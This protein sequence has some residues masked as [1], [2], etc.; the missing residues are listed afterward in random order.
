MKTIAIQDA[1]ILIDLVKTGLFGHCLALD[2]QFVTTDIVLAELYEDQIALIQPHIDSER[3]TVI[4]LTGNVLIE[5]QQA[6]LEDQRL[7]EQDWSALYVAQ[8]EGVLLLTGDKLLRS[9]AVSKG[10]Q[11]YG[12][13][14]LLDKLVANDH[15]QK[16][17]AYIFLTNL[18][19]TNKR[20]PGKECDIR[21]KKWG[22]DEN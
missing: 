11:V 17:E 3:F 18:M 14:W 19:N 9:L 20:L 16:S 7:S 12:L 5:I 13:L 10:I 4:N 2:H 1:N 21:L 8:Q 22:S 15:L 6:S